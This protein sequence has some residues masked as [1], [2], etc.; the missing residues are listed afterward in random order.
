MSYS[1]QT[2][3]SGNSSATIGCSPLL[4]YT[5]NK[6]YVNWS[7]ILSKSWH[8]MILF[9]WLNSMA[10]NFKRAYWSVSVRRY[11]E[12]VHVTVFPSLGVELRVPS[13][14]FLMPRFK[15]TF[16]FYLF[17]GRGPGDLSSYCIVSSALDWFK[18]YSIVSSLS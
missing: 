2:S 5:I 1:G 3:S 11:L 7:H 15:S 10:Y 8:K 4:I 12:W 6:L 13:A 18:N 9:D 14:V 16:V 17:V